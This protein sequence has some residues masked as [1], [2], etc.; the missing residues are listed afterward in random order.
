MQDFIWEVLEDTHGSDHN[1]I[2]LMDLR[3]AHICRTNKYNLKKADWKRFSAE[4]RTN[5]AQEV[6]MV[7]E[8][9]DEF[10]RCVIG[11]ADLSIPKSSAVAH[12][13]RVPWW[14]RECSRV[15]VERKKALRW[16]QRSRTINHQRKYTH[17]SDMG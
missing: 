4:T 6:H 17:V 5:E 12:L 11:A 9:V 2:S 10:N 15:N 8:A 16:Y 7:E 14:T 1:P 13:R 3:I